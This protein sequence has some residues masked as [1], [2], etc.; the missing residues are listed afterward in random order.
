[1]GVFKLKK[2]M[3]I[4]ACAVIAIALFSTI[5]VCNTNTE[6]DTNTNTNIDSKLNDENSGSVSYSEIR[7]DQ[8]KLINNSD[9]IV[10]C[11]FTGEKETKSISSLT[12]NGR[13]EE[14]GFEAPVTTYKMK[15]V[16]SLKGS[17]NDEFEFILLGTGDRNFK[18]DGEYVLFLNYNSQ[19]NIY[20]L[21]SY[22][23]GFNKVKQ[24]SNN[25]Q[26]SGALSASSDEPIEIQSV[27][28]NEVMNYKELKEKIKELQK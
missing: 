5:Y 23:Q 7:Y 2:K 3:I 15:T 16:E 17:V 18:K 28:T 14:D 9:L 22:S 10:R 24:E 21:V 8:D 12:K 11:I 4:G 20:K 6:T 26:K 27:D 19:K 25:A 1:M 13:G